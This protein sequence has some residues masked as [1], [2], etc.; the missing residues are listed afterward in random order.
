MTR[1]GRA[2][3]RGATAVEAAI[4]YPVLV[5]LLFGLIVGGLGVF[6][7]QQV[8][9]LAHEGARA[10]SVRGSQWAKETN[11]TSP[12]QQQLSDQLKTIAAGMDPTQLTVQV[13]WVD[14]ASGTVVAWDSSSKKTTSLTTTGDP[15]ANH[16]RVTVTY[17]WVPEL[18]LAGPL[19]FKSVSEV[20][21]TF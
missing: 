10:A 14:M 11:Q 4:V 3:R 15:V 8:A 2:S 21:Q 18:F 6:R 1:P 19:T 17:Q 16:V 20:P 12:T 7:Y 5:L 9:L 13:D